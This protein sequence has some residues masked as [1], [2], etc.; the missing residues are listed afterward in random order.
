MNIFEDFRT[1]K[2][3]DDEISKY[4][5]E[6]IYSKSLLLDID[7]ENLHTKILTY[8][9][10]KNERDISRYLYYL[11]VS[12][13]LRDIGLNYELVENKVK[14]EINEMKGAINGL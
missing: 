10:S 2:F 5:I 3:I 12:K 7:K 11:K 4:I 1:Y 9:V 13:P 8:M 14:N 6:S